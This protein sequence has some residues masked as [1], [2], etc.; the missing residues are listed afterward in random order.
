LKHAR[1]HLFTTQSCIPL[2]GRTEQLETGYVY[3]VG[4][5][6]MGMNRSGFQGCSRKV[7]KRNYIALKSLTRFFTRSRAP[8][9]HLLHCR[10]NESCSRVRPGSANRIHLSVCSR[11]FMP[12]CQRRWGVNGLYDAICAS[13]G[14]TRT[15]VALQIGQASSP[16]RKPRD[17]HCDHIHT[18]GESVQAIELHI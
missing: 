6:R 5:L 3:P 16:K 7:E 18:T 13:F 17:V 1:L 14:V 10:R 9:L 2:V 15:E 4:V 8:L 12:D 11:T